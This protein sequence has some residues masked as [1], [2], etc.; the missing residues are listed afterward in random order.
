MVLVVSPQ[1]SQLAVSVDNGC[2]YQTSTSFMTCLG[3]TELISVTKVLIRN[4]YLQGTQLSQWDRTTRYVSKFVPCFM[5]YG[6]YKG[7]YIG[8]IRFPVSLQLKP[9]FYRAPFFEVLSLISQ[10]LR[11]LPDSEHIP[12]GS[13]IMYAFVLLCI[14]Q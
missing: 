6:C 14:S 9:C 13:H 4:I 10:N 3:L 12:F 5:S 2:R 1:K 11:R 7:H 8:H